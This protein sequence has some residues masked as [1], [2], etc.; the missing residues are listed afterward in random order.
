MEDLEG[1]L[2]KE[3][4]RVSFLSK[5]NKELYDEMQEIKQQLK[6]TQENLERETGKHREYKQISHKLAEELYN[7]NSN[8][9]CEQCK[10]DCKH[11]YP[12][13]KY[14]FLDWARSEVLKDE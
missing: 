12:T 5:L 2:K 3:K 4:A 11:T 13:S 10:E 6:T 7:S 8:T 1:K 9:C 14:C